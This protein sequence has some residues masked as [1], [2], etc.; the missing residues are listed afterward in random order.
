MFFGYPIYAHIDSLSDPGGRGGASA[1]PTG[2]VG[3]TEFSSLESVALSAQTVT[4]LS[5]SRLSHA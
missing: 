3:Y 1:P 5:G 2:P 4:R